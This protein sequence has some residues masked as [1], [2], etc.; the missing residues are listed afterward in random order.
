[1]TRN[2][3]K[4]PPPEFG[5]DPM[6]DNRKQRKQVHQSYPSDGRHEIGWIWRI[7]QMDAH[8]LPQ[9]D[10]NTTR[11]ELNEGALV[12]F[13]WPPLTNLQQCES[14][15]SS[16]MHEPIAGTRR[17]SVSVRRW[18]QVCGSLS[19]AIAGD[20]IRA[21]LVQTCLLTY[22]PGWTLTLRNKQLSF[23]VPPPCMSTHGTQLSSSTTLQTHGLPQP[24]PLSKSG[25]SPHHPTKATPSD[26]SH[27]PGYTRGGYR[28][29]VVRLRG[30]QTRESSFLCTDWCPAG[31]Y[32]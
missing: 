9:G 21:E 12:F 32:I 23:V 13:C 18:N 6:L 22:D 8:N 7:I 17:S 24:T 31:R 19:G 10:D 4:S 1:M 2:D 20:S 15:G 5:N 26:K 29:S 30:W 27:T 3:L 25:T 11:E 16:R 14:T 28:R